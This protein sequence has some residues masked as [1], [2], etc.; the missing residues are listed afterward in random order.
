MEMKRPLLAAGSLLF[1]VSIA[2]SI[3]IVA[4]DEERCAGNPDSLAKAKTIWAWSESAP[5]QHFRPEDVGPGGT[6]RSNLKAGDEAVV[7]LQECCPANRRP[8]LVIAAPA[9]M[10]LDVPENQLPRFPVSREGIVRFPV[11]HS[12]KWRLRVI[13]DRAGTWWIQLPPSRRLALDLSDALDHAIL[14]VDESRLPVKGA[15]ITVMVREGAKSSD[16]VARL[17]SDEQGSAGLPSLPEGLLTLVVRGANHA[18][19]V[20]TT[21]VQSLP[22]T[23]QLD[24]GYSVKGNFVDRRKK[25]VAAVEVGVEGWLTDSNV[26]VGRTARSDDHGRW[27][28]DLLPANTR[29]IVATRKA[30]FVST[31]SEITLAGSSLDMG[32]VT[33]S[34]GTTIHVQV[35]GDDE[36]PVPHA[37]IRSSDGRRVTADN[38]GAAT[39]T[40]IDP[41]APADLSVSADGYIAAKITLDAP[42]KQTSIARLTR[43]FMVTGQFTD[44]GNGPLPD[45]SIA[46]ADGHRSTTEKI[47]GTGF[48]LPLSPDR[49]LVL[50]F[51]SSSSGA[52]R[53]ELRGKPGDRLDLGILHPPE[54]GRI[55]GRV[56]DPE[57]KPVAAAAIWAPRAGRRGTLLSWSSGDLLR[58]ETDADGGF[59]LAG[60]GNDPLLLRIDA[61]GFARSF[62]LVSIEAET[63]RGDAGDIT[64]TRGGTVEVR[65]KEV[66]AAKVSVA[67]EA[68]DRDMDAIVGATEQGQATLAHVPVGGVTVIV[69]R[70]HDVLCTR[71]ADV[72]EGQTTVVDCNG[73]TTISG[74]VK[75]GDSPAGGGDLLWRLAEDGPVNAVI[76]NSPTPLGA[77]RQDVFGMPVQVAVP[78]SDSGTF[79]TDALRPGQWSVRWVSAHGATTASRTIT[80]AD[81]SAQVDLQYP[82]ATI[83]G[84]VTD[85]QSRPL[86]RAVVQDLDAGT[87]TP[88]DA[89]GSFAFAGALAGSH[90]IRARSSEGARSDVL[91]LQVQPDRDPDPVT[92][93]V[94]DA[95]VT[96][97]HIDVKNAS[98]QPAALALVILDFGSGP[99]VIVTTDSAG[100]A[101]VSL[102]DD[103]QQPVRAAVSFENGIVLG[104][105]RTP[106]QLREPYI[107]AAGA[108]GALSVVSDDEGFVRIRSAA[109]WDVTALLQ[110]LGVWAKLSK[111]IPFIVNGLPEGSYNLSVNSI[112]RTATVKAGTTTAVKFGS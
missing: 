34:P 77:V 27:Q 8:P 93:L 92:L 52:V 56:I 78:L 75:L 68:H 33:L 99:S 107:L 2:A 39:L 30:G 97:M 90:R 41:A 14:L 13:G 74:S 20:I 24:R 26:A 109:G 94:K 67:P 32:A 70:A 19:R 83:Q 63:E 50:E 91:T 103:Q 5:P 9:E 40:D 51:R 62:H 58:A 38:R 23:I 104:D 22:K 49:D 57:G 10:W 53:R 46:I 105:W 85:D 73:Q 72:S 55:R 76:Q 95:N 108:T 44:A 106:A 102:P 12:G 79:S 71:L 60:A 84:R 7:T 17:R 37:A 96:S 45:A 64:V 18:P 89:N 36:R 11:F 86:S 28:V 35:V 15:A 101:E 16:V 61:V 111:G 65:T 88:T 98:G 25:P 48:E 21:S 29:L 47:V 31:R 54:A 42:F 87:S 3:H 82:A 69:S 66:T 110:R 112:M 80:I 4:C 59:E 81:S 1:S 43:A 100:T 6:P